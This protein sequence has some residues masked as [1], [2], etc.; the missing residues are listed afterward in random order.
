MS[1]IVSY[2]KEWQHLMML[3]TGGILKETFKFIW[4]RLVFYLGLF[5][6][7]VYIKLLPRQMDEIYCWLWLITILWFELD[8][9]LPKNRYFVQILH[10]IS[11]SAA[12][13][14]TV[15]MIM[16]SVMTSDF[17]VALTT[18]IRNTTQMTWIIL[19]WIVFLQPIWFVLDLFLHRDDYILRHKFAFRKSKKLRKHLRRILLFLW[20][21]SSLPLVVLTW[22]YISPETTLKSTIRQISTTLLPVI[23]ITHIISVSVLIAAIYKFPKK[24]VAVPQ[25]LTQPVNDNLVSENELGMYKDDDLGQ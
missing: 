15:G 24:S 21:F 14:S 18:V 9:T 13:V 23:T 25:S 22:Y 1:E 17:I 3:S 5:S 12:F 19:G 16:I 7:L 8:V 6:L 20:W 2:P 10:G 4:R 11:F